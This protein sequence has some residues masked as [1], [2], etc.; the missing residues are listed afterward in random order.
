MTLL[1]RITPDLMLAAHDR[2]FAPCVLS[3]FADDLARRVAR[4]NNGPLLEIAAGTGVLT[5]AI[6]S[7]LSAGM[8]I[9]A[10]DPSGATVDYAT[11]KSGMA[12]VVW[13]LADPHDLP[14]RDATFG[15]VTCQFRMAALGDPVD[16]FKQVR[17]I[18]K[19]GARFVFNVPGAL[20]QN[21][22]ADC[23]QA[24]MDELFPANPP[25][26]IADGLHGYA[27][28]AMID[29]DLTHAGF[30]EAIYTVV[31]LPLVAASANEVATGY[32]LGTSLR[33]ELEQRTRGDLEGAVRAAT[34]ALQDH[35]GSG[36]IESSMR[37]HVISAAG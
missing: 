35:F 26:F 34:L 37:A 3:P 8:T 6:A 1:D 36:P 9:V 32:C 16:V 10:T 22:V 24:A 2:F 20:Q 18:M 28:N 23:L 11:K 15:I 30:T 27:D 12:R 7:T 33:D 25:R 4:L 19:K 21:P 17:R 5:D 14:F 13:Q 29:D 31:D